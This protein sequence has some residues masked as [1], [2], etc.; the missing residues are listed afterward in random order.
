M[1]HYF[2]ANFLLLYR[3]KIKYYTQP[4]EAESTHVSA[5]IVTEQA[6]E[7]DLDSFKEMEAENLEQ[8]EES[9]LVKSND[10][11]KHVTNW[12]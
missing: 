10:N 8:F 9:S 11:G 5:S 1:F 4:P 3:G 6:A 7:F 12:E 2:N